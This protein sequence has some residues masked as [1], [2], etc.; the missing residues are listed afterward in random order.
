MARRVR[1]DATLQ[2]S[3]AEAHN[4]FMRSFAIVDH[5]VEMTLLRDVGSRPG[6]SDVIGRQLKSDARRSWH[7]PV[8]TRR[9]TPFANAP[10]ELA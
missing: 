2:M 8:P 9:T 6:G 7:A 10:A 5:D 4:L 1:V 3:R